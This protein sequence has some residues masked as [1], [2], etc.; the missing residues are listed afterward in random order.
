MTWD[1]VTLA[2]YAGETLALA[3]GVLMSVAGV[4]GCLGAARRW[5]LKAMT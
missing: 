4:A 5:A 2:F 1:D 3:S